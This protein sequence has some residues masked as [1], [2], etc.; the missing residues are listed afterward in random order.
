M[1]RALPT[2]LVPNRDVGVQLHGD[3]AG[4]VLH[5]AAAILDGAPGGKDRAAEDTFFIRTQVSF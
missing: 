3:L 1:E 4:C 2:S 5:Y